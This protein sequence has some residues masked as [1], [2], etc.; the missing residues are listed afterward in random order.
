MIFNGGLVPNYILIKNLNLLD[1]IWS[2]ILPGAV[3]IFNV[4]LMM[5]FIRQLPKDIEEAV[6]I[7]GC[8]HFQCL[9]RII[10]PLSAPALAT[11]VLFSF[12]S[13][14]NAYFDGLIYM[15]KSLNYPLQTFLYMVIASRDITNIDQAASFAEVNATTLKSAQLFVSMVPIFIV[16]PFLQRYFIKG[17]TLGAVKG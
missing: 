13:H 14:W 4:I 15:N 12:L 6:F 7:D 1:N 8:S 3:P 16:Y 11:V 2:L 9:V 5:N 10:I 17:L